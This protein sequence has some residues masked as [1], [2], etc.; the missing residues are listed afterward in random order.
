MRAVGSDGLRLLQ[1]HSLVRQQR[2]CGPRVAFK[3]V[4]GRHSREAIPELVPQPR[5]R[6]GETFVA[7]WVEPTPAWIW[8]L[9]YR[10]RRV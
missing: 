1:V 3:V 7:P 9:R 8:C 10:A 2:L 5:I 4:L 6:V